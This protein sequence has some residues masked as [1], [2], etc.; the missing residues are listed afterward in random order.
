[1]AR[2]TKDAWLNAG[3]GDLTEI[4]VVVDVPAKGDTVKIRAL[5]ATA[6][7]GANSQSITTYEERG[8]QRMRVD[9]V[10]LDILRFQAGVVEP[11]FSVEEVRQISNTFGATFTK[12]VNKI[13]ELSGLSNEAVKETEARFQGSGG[14][15]APENGSGAPAGDAG[16]DKPVRTRAGTRADGN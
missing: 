1:M 11:K 13:N 4:E 6:A 12:V 7:N 10:M 14:D 16:S 15:Q 5:S 8:E 3:A 9:S 2:S